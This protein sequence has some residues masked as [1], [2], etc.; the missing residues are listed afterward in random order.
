MT[1]PFIESAL[2]QYASWSSDQ[3]DVINASQS[4]IQARATAC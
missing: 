3:L 1:K 2:T 4:V